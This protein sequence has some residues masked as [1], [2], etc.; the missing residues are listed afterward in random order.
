MLSSNLKIQEEIFSLR[1]KVFSTHISSSISDVFTN[2]SLSD[3]TLVS[4][5]LIQFNT[6]SSP[7]KSS[8]KQ[9][10]LQPINL[11]KRCKTARVAVNPTVCLSW[12][13]Q[14]L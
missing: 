3:V 13:G 11:P 7:E 2:N 6:Q 9:S 8:P 5:D 1:W 10:P 12:E 4:D 14:I